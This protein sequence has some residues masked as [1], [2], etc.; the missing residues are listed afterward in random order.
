MAQVLAMLQAVCGSYDNIKTPRWYQEFEIFGE[1]FLTTARDYDT[2][3]YPYRPVGE[4]TPNLYHVLALLSAGMITDF[5]LGHSVQL[6]AR[7]HHPITDWL[8]A[9]THLVVVFNAFPFFK[10]WWAYGTYRV[11]SCDFEAYVM[12][13]IGERCDRLAVESRNPP[14]A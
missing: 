13:T 1:G 10:T 9:L 3:C 11:S 4:V 8:H 14:E 7:G 2:H 12:T 6:L 5:T